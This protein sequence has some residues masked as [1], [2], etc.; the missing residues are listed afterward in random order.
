MRKFSDIY[1]NAT[2]KAVSLL[3]QLL[4]FDPDRRLTVEQCLSHPFLDTLHDPADE[5][6]GLGNLDFTWESQIGGP[7]QAKL[8]LKVRATHP[9]AQVLSE[10]AVGA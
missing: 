4:L 2:P 5:P 1:P 8:K 6:G 7:A 10:A 3:E 9:S